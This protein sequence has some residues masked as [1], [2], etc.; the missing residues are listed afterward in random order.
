[1]L[2]LGSLLS[3][4]MRCVA[5][6][7]EELTGSDEGSGVLELPTDDIGPLVGQERQ[8]TMRADPLAETGVHDCLGGGSD[9]DRFRHLTL[10][11]LSHPCDLRSESLDVAL[12]FV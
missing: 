3:G 9:G 4:C 10:S 12:L 8:V 1:M 11:T 5:L 7:P 6:L 2:E